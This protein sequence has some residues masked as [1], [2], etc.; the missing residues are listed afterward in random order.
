MFELHVQPHVGGS[1]VDVIPDIV[2]G[3]GGG[4]GE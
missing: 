1:R 2:G 4:T 3:G